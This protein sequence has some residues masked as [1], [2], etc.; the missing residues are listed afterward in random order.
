MRAQRRLHLRIQ[1]QA[2]KRQTT[3]TLMTIQTMARVQSQV[4]TRK[5]RMA[6]VNEAL[7]RQLLQKREKEF[8]KVRVHS[9]H[10]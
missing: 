6:E 2:V 4:R 3:S 10:N 8:D 9:F 5:I 1:G 7:Q